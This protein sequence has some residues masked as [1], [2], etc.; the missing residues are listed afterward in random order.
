MT[1]HEIPYE[2]SEKELLLC[3]LERDTHRYVLVN[4]QRILKLETLTLRQRAEVQDE[5]QKRRN[6]L[7]AL[8][9]EDFRIKTNMHRYVERRE[10]KGSKRMLDAIV[11]SNYFH[12]S[13][14]RSERH[15]APRS[16][17]HRLL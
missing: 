17:V 6:L 4:L 12:A 7:R 1:A 13:S 14:S 2:R 3:T 8:H 15:E 16:S 10:A 5:I 11:I 9:T